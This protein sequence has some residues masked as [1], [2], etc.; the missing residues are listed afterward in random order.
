MI[1]LSDQGAPPCFFVVV[2]IDDLT[3]I[4]LSI[5]IVYAPTSAAPAPA[6]QDADD[7]DLSDPA[8]RL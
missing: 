6:P 5:L 4:V 8:A 2:N 1:Y 3:R 7:F